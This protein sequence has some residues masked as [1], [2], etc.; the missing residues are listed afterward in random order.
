MCAIFRQTS[1]KLS[2]WE[3]RVKVKNINDNWTLST[4]V[5]EEFLLKSFSIKVKYLRYYAF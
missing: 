2:Q 3:N 5:I 1:Q 4:K